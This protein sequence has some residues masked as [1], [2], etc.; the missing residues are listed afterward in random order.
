MT[1]NQSIIWFTA[2]KCASVYASEILQKLAEDVGMIYRNDEGD[3]WEKGQSL[4]NLIY[5]NDPETI[6]NLKI[7]GWLKDERQ[8]ADELF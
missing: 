4:E 5:G 6:N 8:E 1:T 2:H 3:L 7:Y